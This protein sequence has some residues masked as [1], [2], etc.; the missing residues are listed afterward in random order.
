MREPKGFLVDKPLSNL[1]AKLPVQMR[2]EIKKLQRRLGITSIYVTPDQVKAMTMAD[3]LVVLNAGRVEQ[4]G[5]PDE[6][7]DRPAT[8]FVANFIESPA[9]HLLG[10]VITADGVIKFGEHV[11]GASGGRPDPVLVGIRPE[12]LAITA[13]GELPAST[14]MVEPLGAE[15]L[16]HADFEGTSLTVPL[17]GKLPLKANESLRLA[18]IGDA[19]RH[20]FDPASGERIENGRTWKV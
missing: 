11:I 1:D 17:S 12:H 16:V 13:D 5:T 3:R 9:M 8:R 7:Y 19:A 20:L 6:V 18:A 15:T 14:D 4:I 2:L 10:G